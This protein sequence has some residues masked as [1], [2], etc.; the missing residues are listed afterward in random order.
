MTKSIL[1][2]SPPLRIR[3]GISA[4][5]INLLRGWLSLGYSVQIANPYLFSLRNEV[6][7]KS[8]VELN[9]YLLTG[10]KFH[11]MKIKPKNF[12]L[13]VIQY[14]ISS[15]WLQTFT[16]NRWLKRSLA[17]K[18]ILLCHEPSR[19]LA[20]LGKFGEFIYSQ[21]IKF[22]TK[23]CTFSQSGEEAL[24]R[25]TKSPVS[26]LPL[27][28]PSIS[29]SVGSNDRVPHFLL[30]GYYLKEKGF[31]IGLES[32]LET[33]LKSPESVHLDLVLSPRQRLGSARIFS[34]RDRRTYE[35]FIQKVKAAVQEFPDQIALRGYLD[36]QE[37]TELLNRIDFILLPY[38]SIT[39]SGVAVTSKAHG[40][41]VISSPLPPL[42]QALEGFALFPT[43]TD[44]SSWSKELL[45]LSS[46]GE[47]REIRA[48]L[49][50]TSIHFRLTES[51]AKIAARII[52]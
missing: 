11:S 48:R 8:E 39:N 44:A 27:S 12:E 47:W 31:E 36:D 18:R 52:E 13:V 2:I 17:K 38:L 15:Y 5:S 46:N 16:L 22:S 21:A 30:L 45:D 24:T 41:P 28:V 37:L 26:M 49:S 35:S 43:D 4:H 1:L 9:E 25:F 14:A 51:S 10:K 6:H 3:D 32:V 7:L 23:I 20:I 19:E 34:S 42:R 33:L 29:E 40:V 50:A